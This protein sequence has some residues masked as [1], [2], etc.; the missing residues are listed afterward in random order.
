MIT[1]QRGYNGNYLPESNSNG[2]GQPKANRRIRDTPEPSTRPVLSLAA[3]V[4]PALVA[5]I[6]AVT[7]FHAPF[8]GPAIGFWFLILNPA[9]LLCTTD[10]WGGS[11]AIERVGYSVTGVLL[12]LMLSGLV[13]NTILPVLGVAGPLASS[14]VVAVGDLATIALYLFREHRPAIPKWSEWRR[15]LST[16]E[17]R[18]IIT[19]AISPVLGVLG[20][21]RLNNGS[22]DTIALAT[23]VVVV[24][25]VIMLLRWHRIISDETIGI[26]LFF[27]ALAL[28]V[29]NS[30]RGWYVT[31]HD[32]QTEYRVF[33]L[34]AAHNR[35]N[36]GSLHSAYNACL[37]LTILPTEINNIVHVDAPYVYKFFF[38]FLFAL[39]PTLVYAISR[40]FAPKSFA[41]LGSTYFIG[42]PTF[43][44]DMPFLNRQEIAFL[45]VCVGV[46]SITNRAWPRRRRRIVLYIAAVGLELSHYSST[47]LFLGV[48]LVSLLVEPAIRLVASLIYKIRGISGEPWPKSTRTIGFGPV[49]V[50]A[51]IIAIWG[52]LLTQT[53]GSLVTQLNAAV[54]QITTTTAGTSYSL[55]SGSGISPQ[56]ALANTRAAELRQNVDSPASM[57]IPASVVEQ[58]Q[59][60]IDSE[61]NLPLTRIGRAL[62]TV[63]VPISGLNTAVRQ[64]A[65]K[66]EQLFVVVGFAGF[67]FSSRLR[68]RVSLELLYICFASIVMVA[69][70]AVFPSLAVD[71]GVLRAFQ[72]SLLLTSTVLVIGS[73]VTFSSFGMKWALRITTNVA[74]LFFIS[75]IGLMPQLLGGY[76]AQLG[77]NNSGSYYD[78]FYTQP[79]EVRAVNWLSRQPGVLPTGVQAPM[80]QSTAGRFDFNTPSTVNGKQ[81]VA[82][83]YPALILRSDW[84]ILGYATVRYGRA[85]ISING[86]LYQYQYPVAPLQGNKNLVFNDGGTQIYR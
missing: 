81:G 77:L 62:A 59:T 30:L 1:P 42:F 6:L 33:Q 74:V 51:I 84:I 3:V 63:G 24:L 67:A 71:Y 68:R 4:V 20:A 25:A 2:T 79:Q 34:T 12:W 45:F 5:N 17:I 54:Q 55:F 60:P 78:I 14:L 7:G 37:S 72:E 38:Q 13:L 52:G 28:L 64:G 83:I 82:D 23:L 39:C 46:L 16:L 80:G 31:G 10:I 53:A 11:N 41:V 44:N 15:S 21:N 8:W 86:S 9:Y 73:V 27:V 49:A 48:L 76:P 65:A 50:V 29:S 70:F 26:A 58:Y 66:D 22:D 47:Y 75:T 36:V 40:R 69:F 43:F 57:Y 18:V 35:W 19:A 61:P 56:E 32:I 85:P